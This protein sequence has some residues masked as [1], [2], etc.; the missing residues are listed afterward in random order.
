MKLNQQ[1][2]DK[3]TN[4]TLSHYNQRAEDFWRGTRDHDV[5]QNIAALLQAIE[6]PAPF[7]ILDFGCGPGRD[8]KAF[9]DLGHVAVGLE[10]AA[11]FA[12]MA[13]AY[14]GCEVWQQDF[15]KL[16]L[17]DQHF[18]GVF[19]NA[20]LFHV[21]AQELSRVLR[22]LCA[23]LKPGGVLFA[24][25]PRGDNQEG[26]NGERYGAY[27]DL[28][29]WRRYVSGAGF[30]ELSHYYRPPGLPRA[31]QPWLASVWRRG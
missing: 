25:N 17:P 13:R 21:P 22:E 9:V 31:Q 26:W 28:E 3:I 16:D 23:T 20:S 19:A 15:L 12:A 8:L 18:D 1:D 24:S 5:G 6:G 27:H 10:G 30:V 29:S 4:V 7:T 11:E 2:L 14:T